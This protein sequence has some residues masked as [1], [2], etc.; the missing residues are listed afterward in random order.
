MLKH[1][2]IMASATLVIMLSASV[3]AQD[4]TAEATR[5][6][7]VATVNGTEITI[8]QMIIT[9]AQLPQQYQDLPDDVLFSGILEQLVQQQLLADQM[10]EDPARVKIALDNQRRSLLAGEVINALTLGAVTED[11]IKAAYEARFANAAPVTEYHAAH[12]LVETQEE[13]L[14]VKARIDAGADFTDTAREMSTGPSGPSGGDLGWF[15]EGMMVPEFEEAVFALEPEQVSDPVQTQ[16]GW[17]IIKLLETRI[18]EAPTLD[19]LRNELVAQIQQAAVEA[20]LAELTEAAEIVMPEQG[21]FDPTVLK[22]L[23]LLAE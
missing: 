13:A 21:A 1:A 23:D 4:S 15:S 3:R 5:D 17:H 9:R 14:A 18:K 7:V 12:I 10:T 2:T 20:K 11:A 8:G 16:F 22:N 6:T 19:D